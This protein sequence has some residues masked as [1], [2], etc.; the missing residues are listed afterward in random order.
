MTY[1]GSYRSTGQR[2]RNSLTSAGAQ[3]LH[4][5]TLLANPL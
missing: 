4:I 1:T 2:S 5:H 3:K